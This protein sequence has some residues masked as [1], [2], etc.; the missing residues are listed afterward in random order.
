MG[1]GLG[2]TT[3]ML[4]VSWVKLLL[5]VPLTLLGLRV[6]VLAAFPADV[7]LSNALCKEGSG[8]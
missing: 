6:V 5:D 7:R 8:R 2:L 3:G 4:A 1:N